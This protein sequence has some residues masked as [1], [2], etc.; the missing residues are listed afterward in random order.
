MCRKQ[1]PVHEARIVE[2]GGL[3]VFCALCVGTVESYVKFAFAKPEERKSY[4][5]RP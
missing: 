2:A 3:L 1:K 4:D 5:P